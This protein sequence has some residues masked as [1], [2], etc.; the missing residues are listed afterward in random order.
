MMGLKIQQE[1]TGLSFGSMTSTTGTLFRVWVTGASKVEVLLFDNPDGEISSISEMSLEQENVWEWSAPENLHQKYYLYRVHRNGTYKETPD[2]YSKSSSVNGSKSMVVDFSCLNPTGWENQPLIN[3]P[4][5]ESILYELHLRDFSVSETSGVNQKGGYLSLTERNTFSPRGN[6][7]NL[8]HLIDL[9]VTHVHVLPVFDFTSVDE[10]KGGYNWGYDPYL[11]NVLEGSYSTNPHDGVTKVIEF[12][13]MVQSLHESGIGIILDVV[14]NHTSHEKES[15]FDILAPKGYYRTTE[16]GH[17]SNG[18]GC[19]NELDTENPVVRKF[20]ID[21]L[22]FWMTEYKVDGFRFD[23]MSLYDVETVHAIERELRELNPNVILYGEPWIGGLSILPESKR[24][25]KG[26]QWDTRIGLFNDEVRDA[27]KGDNDGDGTGF[28]MGRHGEEYL[29][30]AA[31][32]GGIQYDDY[33]KG[34]SKDPCQTINYVSCHDNLSLYDKIE[35]T[36]R[37]ASAFDRIQM[38]KLSLSIL[39]TSFG[40]PFLHAGSE[41][42]RSKHGHHNSYNAGDDVN[43]IDWSLKDKHFDTYRYIRDL[44]RFRKDQRV[45][46]TDNANIVR[47]SLEFIPSYH[48]VITYKITSPFEEDF[49]EILIVHNGNGYGVHIPFLEGEEWI[50]MANGNETYLELDE[51]VSEQITVMPISSCI[52]VKP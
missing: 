8:D 19:G 30:M 10:T 16:C 23:L 15:P 42:L 9:G 51:K 37:W 6:K 24:F 2:P 45:F 39:L 27:I 18:S 44:I 40:V 11:Y 25:G 36:A 49:R 5:S 52:L 17:Y 14:Y 48:G 26:H 13:K 29:V 35:K 3:T 47:S 22:K 46:Q 7:T 20:I 41:F 38:N 31:I 32:S 21:S 12:K 33:L 4:L 34:F 43:Q 28:V 50:L 1:L